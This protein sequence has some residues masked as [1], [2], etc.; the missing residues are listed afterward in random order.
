MKQI[1]SV[2]SSNKIQDKIITKLFKNLNNLTKE[3]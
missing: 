2:E 1:K 3:F